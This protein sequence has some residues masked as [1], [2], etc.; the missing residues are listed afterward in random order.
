MADDKEPMICR[1][2][3]K[4]DTEHDPSDC[5]RK[6]TERDRID[7]ERYRAL[8]FWMLT[9]LPMVDALPK[10]FKGPLGT[11]DAAVGLIVEAKLK[12]QE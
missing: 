9:N 2:C 4:S 5:L 1:S 11:F 6:Q 10:E 7:A 12:T 3:F 8:K